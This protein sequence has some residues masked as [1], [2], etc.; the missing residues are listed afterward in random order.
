MDNRQAIKIVRV[1]AFAAVF[2]S[3]VAAGTVL[4]VI[5]TILWRLAA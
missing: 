1:I 2:A 3:F 4:A 5:G